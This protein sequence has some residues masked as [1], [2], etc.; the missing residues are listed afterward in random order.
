MPTLAILEQLLKDLAAE[1]T[2]LTSPGTLY[3]SPVIIW[4]AI[5][6]RLEMQIILGTGQYHDFEGGIRTGDY[7]LTIAI[8][9]KCNLDFDGR[10]HHSLLRDTQNIFALKERVIA[11]LEGSFLTGTLLTRPLRLVTDVEI[12]S[13]PQFENV[14][15]KRLVFVGG[16]NAIR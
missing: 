16:H 8:F 9:Y 6:Q 14:L 1:F 7:T 5:L 2:E 10:H 4:P 12:E 13:H 15:L 3:V 11:L